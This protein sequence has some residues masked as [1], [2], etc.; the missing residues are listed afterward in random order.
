MRRFKLLQPDDEEIQK[1]EAER[2]R[3]S[4]KEWLS[5]LFWALV[6][7]GGTIWLTIAIMKVF[8]DKAKYF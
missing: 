5:F 3:R 8:K 7:G 4:L 6:W 2:P 1:E